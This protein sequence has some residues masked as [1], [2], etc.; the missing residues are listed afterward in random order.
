[1]AAAV[2]D[3]RNDIQD[4]LQKART[5][6]S[7]EIGKA[8]EEFEKHVNEITGAIGELSALVKVLIEKFNKKKGK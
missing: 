5:E 4:E 6:I 2:Y 1:M 8:K 7:N 3:A